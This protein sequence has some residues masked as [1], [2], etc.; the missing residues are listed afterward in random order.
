MRHIG[1][2]EVGASTIE[3]AAKVHPIVDLQ[4]EYSIASRSA[5]EKIFPQLEQL[6]IS[7]TLYGVMSRGLVTGSKPQGAS[8]FRAYLP[9]F[10]G[11]NRAQNEDVETS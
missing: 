2:S 11:D 10:A 1:L 9:R 6:G 3:R 8:D 4:I 5:E 7:A